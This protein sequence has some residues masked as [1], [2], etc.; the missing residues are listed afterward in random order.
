[1]VQSAVPSPWYTS[2]LCS[3]WCEILKRFTKIQNTYPRQ[4]HQGK[5]KESE[6][7]FVFFF[8]ES[9]K[10]I[11]F[12][13]GKVVRCPWTFSCA[14]RTWLIHI[15]QSATDE[16]RLF[17]S[18][19]S[20][21]LHINLSATNVRRCCMLYAVNT[22]NA[23]AFAKWFIYYPMG[24]RQYLAQQFIISTVNVLIKLKLPLSRAHCHK[25]NVCRTATFYVLQY[26]I[27]YQF[28]LSR[29]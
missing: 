18:V 6:K 5:E 29:V 12:S 20:K 27:S 4:R 3:I 13:S 23:F 22:P 19:Y 28:T 17:V 11:N 26:I 7:F 14:S 1:M 8:N 10:L 21:I 9:R 15:K 24:K 25:W 2:Y 16:F